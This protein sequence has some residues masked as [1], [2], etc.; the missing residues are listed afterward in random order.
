VKRVRSGQADLAF[1]VLGTGGAGNGDGRAGRTDVVLLHAGVCDRRGWGELVDALTTAGHRV[2]AFDRRGF[3]ETVYVPEPHSSVD[4]TLAVVAAA[5]MGPAVAV[6]G[7][8]MGGRVALDLALAHPDRV[9][10]LVLIG[11]AVRGAPDPD[12][13]SAAVDRLVAAIDAAEDAG[14]LDE[15]NR[16]EAH[17]WL[18]GPGGPE[19]RVGGEP[20][21]LFMEMNGRA[22]AAWDAGP[23]EP[24]PSAWD[25]LAEIEVPALVAVGELDLPHIRAR[26][27][28]IADQLPR[29]RLLELHGVAH[30]PSLE[31][32][33]VLVDEVCRFLAP[34]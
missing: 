27:A 26:S 21:A 13:S 20:R 2:V 1:D 30:L 12:E 4:D 16:L 32:S 24:L 9:E 34:P 8:S 28:T 22:L 19:G 23:E 25:R 11:T 7:N 6:V 18:D 5:G 15:V 33:D 3:G 31:G 29:G 10:T 17:L 14:D